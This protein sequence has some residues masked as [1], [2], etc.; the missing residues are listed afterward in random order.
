MLWGGEESVSVTVW[1][2]LF[3]LIRVRSVLV[4]YRFGIASVVS[5]SVASV[6]QLQ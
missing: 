1:R 6:V 2:F 4:W 5:D 3:W